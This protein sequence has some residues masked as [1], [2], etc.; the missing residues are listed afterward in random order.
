MENVILYYAS[1]TE[2]FRFNFKNACQAIKRPVEI[3]GKKAELQKQKQKTSVL[4]YLYKRRRE[5][6]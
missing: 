3:V 5:T 1:R 6:L 2:M 4:K